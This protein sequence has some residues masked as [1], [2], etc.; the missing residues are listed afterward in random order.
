MIQLRVKMLRVGDVED[1]EIYLGAVAHD[2]L[3]SEHG[4]YVKEKAKDLMYH[5]APLANDGYYG[6][7]LK[8]KEYVKKI[9]SVSGKKVE[10]V[11]LSSGHIL[12]TWDSIVK[13][14]EA[15]SICKTKMSRSIKNKTIFTDYFYRLKS[16]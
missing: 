16:N 14:A 3:Q 9:V 5:Q 1:P 10:K 15:E 11:E 4:K 12:E 2:W 6:L 13:A 7:A 8:N